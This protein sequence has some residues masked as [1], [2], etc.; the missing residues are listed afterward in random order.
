MV[1]WVLG[2]QLGGASRGV[3][4]L[5]YQLASRRQVG[6]NEAGGEVARDPGSDPGCCS[7]MVEEGGGG[8]YRWLVRKAEHEAVAGGFLPDSVAETTHGRHGDKIKEK[9][10]TLIKFLV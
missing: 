10:R 6:G 1:R 2:D 4:R 9:K 5:S 7:E 3:T 8:R